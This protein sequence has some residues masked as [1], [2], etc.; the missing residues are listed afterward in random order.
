MIELKSKFGE[1]I[2]KYVSSLPIFLHYQVYLFLP[3]MHVTKT[4]GTASSHG[5]VEW[6]ASPKGTSTMDHSTMRTAL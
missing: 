6:K 2:P 4:Y 3:D 5:R 1:F